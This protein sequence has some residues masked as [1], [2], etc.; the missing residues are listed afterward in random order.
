M[1]ARS[2]GAE[3][4]A[5]PQAP[6][7]AVLFH[8]VLRVV[9]RSL[10]HVPS[11]PHRVSVWGLAFLFLVA[12]LATAS[13]GN[14]AILSED[15]PA[16][17][18][19]SSPQHLA[20]TLT[21]AGFS[22]TFLN[23]AQLANEQVL[24]RG[25]FDVVILPYGGSFP[26]RAADCFRGFLH[27]GGKFLSLG[28]YA[29]DNLLDRAADGWH[30]YQP[31]VP[32]RVEGAAWFFELPAEELRGH[33]RLLFRGFLKTQGVAGPGFA[34]YS[35]YQVADDGSLPTWRDLCQVRGTADWTEQHFAFD[36]HPR[37]RTVS[38][39]AGL[40]RCRGTAWFDD[41]RI[42]SDAGTVWVDAGFEEAPEADR[43][44]LRSWWR[45]DAQRCLWQN[46]VAH[47]G[48]NALQATLD[49]QIP[50]TDRLNTRCGR[51]EDGLEVEPTQLGVFQADYLLERA[52][53]AEAAPMQS[54][55]PSGPVL[56]GPIEGWAAAGV[57]G[58]NAA[59]WIPL[60]NAHDRYGRLRGAVGAMLRH[61]AGSW[62]GS[63]WA[64]FGV[65]NVDLFAPGNPQM[66]EA[67]VS[68]TRSLVRDVYLASLTPDPACQEPGQPVAFSAPIFNGGRL[69]R[70]LRVALEFH[71]GVPGPET[72]AAS[73]WT[74]P[75]R[76]PSSPGPLLTNLVF[77]LLVGPGETK[78]V[79]ARITLPDR[80]PDFV[81]A[82]GRICEGAAELDCIESGVVVRDRRTLASGPKLRFRDNYLRFGRRPLLLFGTDDWGHV[83][84]T[85][86]ETPLQWLRDMRQRRDL[87]VLIYE[88][89]QFGLPRSAEER[90]RLFRKVDGIVQLSQKY[91]Q[92][93]FAGL[94]VG[95]NV[96]A[97]DRELESHVDYA[98]AFA[99]RYQSVPGLIY[100]LNGDYRCELGDAVTPHW[101]QFLKERYGTDAALRGAWGPWAPAQPLGGIPSE[102]YRD[103]EQTWDDVSAY[104]RNCFR[105]WLMRRWNGAMI[106]GI[107]RSD[108]SHPTSGE[109]YQLP[110][111]GVDLPS[112]ID[113]LDLAN[114]GFFDRPGVDLARFPAL[115]KYNDQRARGKSGGPG[116]YGVKTHPAWGDGQDYGYHTARTREQSME[117]FLA[118]PHYTLGL[119][120]SRLHN[121]CWKD[122]AQRVFPWGMVYP[123]DGVP[124]DTGLIHRNLSLLFRHFAPVDE[125]PIAYVLT[126]DH[127]RLGGAKWKVMD[128]ILACIDLL[129]ATHVHNLGTLN[130]E[131]L[132]IPRSAR[133]LLYPLP[134]CLPDSTYARIREW[135]QN[136]GVLYVSG[137]LSF[138]ERRRR[139]RTDR[140]EELC[141]VRF[142][143][144]CRPNIAVD[145]TDAADQPVLRVEPGRAAVL[146]QTADHVPLVLENRVGRGR[147]LFTTDP[148]ELHAVPARQAQNLA[149][150][151]RALDL[152]GLRPPGLEP[153]DPELHLFRVATRGGGTVHIVFNRDPNH[154]L[155]SV[156]ITDGPS[157]VTLT[158]AGRRP[159]L[160]WRAASGAL[161][162]VETQGTCRVGDQT[163]LVDETHGIVVALDGADLAHSRALLMMPT[164]PGTIRLFPAQRWVQPVVETGE[165]QNGNWRVCALD[166]IPAAGA[167]MQ[168]QVSPDQALSLLLVAEARA[169]PRWRHAIER[170]MTDP[171]SL[172]D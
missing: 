137:D 41:V 153:D 45:S 27:A 33:G 122:D 83:F 88:N 51:P 160:L 146:R 55:I 158:V 129:L 58:W 13:E 60:M 81:H 105:A 44:A 100:Y 69:A 4:P 56:Q 118:I 6:G 48:S 84:N 144:E 119:G 35:I 24:N 164:R 150:Y 86:R 155:R 136:G 93:Y 156:T 15:L 34:H 170:A 23:S 11:S 30:A 133:L 21:E 138:D 14:V 104:D 107:R 110:H 143:A 79:T 94:L 78:N 39:R 50:R 111:G 68:V 127:H 92:V 22:T 154:P 108:S 123:C 66:N 165:I 126:P 141:G 65:T 75:G 1:N 89:L 117:L 130:E 12:G 151:R 72:S 98:H 37:A 149:L 85:D 90:E 124:K 148:V 135:V 82:I 102:E 20:R 109:F 162:A 145:P 172:A 125:E 29:F 59:R 116:E 167:P 163:I 71:A 76:A 134:Y 99:Q 77:T 47:T 62:A 139:S 171:G 61:Y 3:K 74:G 36:I 40:Y 63:S 52:R 38:L 152:A 32:P 31:P 67:L 49:F 5:D 106:A 91:G 73:Q 8:P 64:F 114:F 112:G 17:G 101:N 10:F 166:P 7:A 19:A 147:V 18:A 70:E 97:G 96:A 95:A 159:G 161:R 28:G 120:A 132:A 16:S 103:W 43:R 121:W 46:A 26:V 128:G 113:G 131:S 2:S 54:I 9:S 140:L 25:S 57:V 53:T 42:T 168:V 157:P 169:I 142:T 87:G 115:C 80:G